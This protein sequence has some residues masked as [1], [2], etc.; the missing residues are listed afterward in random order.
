MAAARL[1]EDDILEFH[2]SWKATRTFGLITLLYQ[3]GILIE[4]TPMPKVRDKK[5]VPVHKANV[6]RKHLLT[7]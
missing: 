4:I 1:D 5:D 3:H 7:A 2:R 6:Q